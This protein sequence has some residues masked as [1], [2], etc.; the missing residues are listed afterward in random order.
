MFKHTFSNG[1][2]V[3]SRSEKDWLAYMLQ[4]DIYLDDDDREA[5]RFYRRI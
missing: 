4:D 2:V 3:T 5:I 1:E